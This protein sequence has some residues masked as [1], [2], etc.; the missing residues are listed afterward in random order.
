[1]GLFYVQCNISFIC[2]H[3]G[4]LVLYGYECRGKDV[5]VL[6][7][8]HSDMALFRSLMILSRQQ[9]GALLSRGSPEEALAMKNDVRVLDRKVLSPGQT[10]FRMGEA[11]DRAYLVQEG[12]IDIIR[13]LPDGRDVVLGQVTRGGIFGEMALV[14]D[15]PRMATAR[16]KEKA[17]L[18]VVTRDQFQ[19]K[20][21][22]ADPFIR[23]LLK[24]FV[25]NIRSITKKAIG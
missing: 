1:M 5:C 24:I 21:E 11:G 25:Q 7:V 16:C 19:Q 23:A 22:A 3:K 6:L 2:A 13:E 12:V 17:V 4:M 14:D 20:L 9:S 18:V 15:Q 8:A 10:L